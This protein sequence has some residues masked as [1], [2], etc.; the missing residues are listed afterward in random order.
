MVLGGAVPVVCVAWLLP[1]FG[2]ESALASGAA[3]MRLSD[4][5]D[6][7]NMAAV[8]AKVMWRLSV[9]V[10][11]RWLLLVVL[12][13]DCVDAASVGPALRMSG[14]KPACSK[15]LW[16]ALSSPLLW[17]SVGWRVDMV[18][19]CGGVVWA[20]LLVLGHLSCLS[21]ALVVAHVE[22]TK[23][24]LSA[25]FAPMSWKNCRE[26]CIP[27][28]IADACFSLQAYRN[29]SSARIRGTT[30]CA[31]TSSIQGR[32]N[33]ATRVIEKGHPW[34]MEHRCWWGAPRVGPILLWM[35]NASW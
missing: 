4:P 5:G 35:T 1:S 6:P 3:A 24:F 10:L 21:L 31:R 28:T 13:T 33:N 8:L 12:C 20:A 2:S 22:A 29:R 25:T 27:L 34:G 16:P 19:V 18:L 32:I 11:W 26:S 7:D 14:E 9:V 15:G 17:A 23:H 30:L